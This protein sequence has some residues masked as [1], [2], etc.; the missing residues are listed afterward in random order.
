[1]LLLPWGGIRKEKKGFPCPHMLSQ[2]N[3]FS[4]PSSANSTMRAEGVTRH[5][6]ERYLPGSE[7]DSSHPR[8]SSLKGK[9]QALVGFGL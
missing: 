8:P 3:L 2:S 9:N 1:M 6:A 5:W 7:F 4:F